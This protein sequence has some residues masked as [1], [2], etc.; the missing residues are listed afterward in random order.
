M[1]YRSRDRLPDG[2]QTLLLQAGS[3]RRA[4]INIKGKGAHLGLTAPP[5]VL[6]VTVQLVR[7]DTSGVCWESHYDTAQANEPGRLSARAAQ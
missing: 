1:R 7:S 5:L 2:L 6:P 3:G 4:R